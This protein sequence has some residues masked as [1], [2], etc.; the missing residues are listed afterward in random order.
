MCG[1]RR[2][3]EF[4]LESRQKVGCPVLR[5]LCRRLLKPAQLQATLTHALNAVGNAR[6]ATR[7]DLFVLT[8]L[9]N[10]VLADFLELA[11]LT[12]TLVLVGGE[13]VKTGAF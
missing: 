2:L 11:K 12:L 1:C 10:S 7:L 13:L 8:P 9:P 3:A 4:E 5:L 6:R